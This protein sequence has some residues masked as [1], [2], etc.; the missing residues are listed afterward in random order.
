L[1]KR[2]GQKRVIFLGDVMLGRGVNEVFW[3]VPPDFIW[4][5]TLDIIKSADYSL[6]NLECAL[7]Y[8]EEIWTETMKAFYFKADPDS[9]IA[10]LRE[11]N[12]SCVCLANNHTLDF[13][14]EGLIDTL[15]YIDEA[16]ICRAGAGENI[17][18]ARSPAFRRVDNII[19]G[20]VAFTDNEPGF[21]ATEDTPGV[22]FVPVLPNSDYFS[23][24]L[25]SVVEAKR[26][27]DIVIVSAHWGPNM[28]FHPLLAFREAA[29]MLI[30]AGADIF[31]GHSAHN[32]QGIEI[33]KGKPILYDTGDFVDDYAID[34]TYR[35]DQSFIFVLNLN[36]VVMESIDL[37]PVHLSYAQT[38]LASE[39]EFTEIAERMER[40]SGELGTKVTRL[41]DRLSISV[42]VN[43]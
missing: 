8:H 25:S 38:N 2:S 22:N 37:Y 33:Y 21:A 16:G 43:R 35:N 15:R 24:L 41:K 7:T 9:A 32:F 10:A 42:S 13:Q 39:P 28:R 6:I 11:A 29:H 31:H 23:P 40:L 27:A 34:P 1:D 4:G 18:E 19:V 17:S 20:L 26:A 36:G 5:T 30:D 12:I 14:Q 3:E